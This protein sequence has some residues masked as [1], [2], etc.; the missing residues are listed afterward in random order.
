MTGTPSS[1]PSATPPPGSGRS[2]SS[3]NSLLAGA[4]NGST[5]D[6]SSFMFKKPNAK[7][8]EISLI[9]CQ[10]Q[11]DVAV[12]IQTRVKL[13][14]GSEGNC[15]LHLTATE[16]TPAKEFFDRL[17]QRVSSTTPFPADE[18]LK[19]IQSSNLGLDE[20]DIQA[21]NVFG[22]AGAEAVSFPGATIKSYTSKS[23]N[24]TVQNINI[25]G[26]R[27]KGLFDELNVRKL[28]ANGGVV[29]A[30]VNKGNIAESSF[31]Q[32]KIVGEYNFTIFTKDDLRA[33]DLSKMSHYVFDQINAGKKSGE[34]QQQFEARIG[35]EIKTYFNETE[36]NFRKS[37]APDWVNS[38]VTVW[39]TDAIRDLFFR[40]TQEKE[41]TNLPYLPAATVLEGISAI[42][43]IKTERKQAAANGEEQLVVTFGES[44]LHFTCKKEHLDLPYVTVHREGAPSLVVP[45]NIAF[46]I[47]RD[48]HQQV[49][50]ARNEELLKRGGLQTKIATLTADMD[51]VAKQLQ[52][53]QGAANAADDELK[54]ARERNQKLQDELDKA[55]L[56]L[57]QPAA[58]VN[59]NANLAQL[60]ATQPAAPKVT[61][62]ALRENLG[63]RS[64]QQLLADY[65]LSRIAA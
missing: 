41:N 63:P 54:R 23:I 58:P 25:L 37:D 21:A 62:E 53:Q 52:E 34:N 15:R 64:M 28:V 35:R 22:P 60:L 48:A 49:A 5:R 16:A 51:A 31:V 61:P 59:I 56:A 55:R 26:G 43:Y 27:L 10:L 50:T 17:K 39:P 45:A 30:K 2:Q 24:F 65:T 7:T 29:N 32:A 40:L 38:F 11:Q 36:F 14:H 47:I 12:N 6:E 8:G 33:A 3:G 19:M 1:T 4:S 18:L 46:S 9:N 13:T 42:K 57:A 20:V 44:T